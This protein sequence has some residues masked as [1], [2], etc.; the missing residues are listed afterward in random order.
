[1]NSLLMF[2]G[3]LD[4]TYALAKLLRET[5]D[6]VIVH[7][8]HLMTNRWQHIAEAER[9]RKIVTYCHENMRPFVYTQ[10]GIDH[11]RFVS[12]GMDLIA[13]GFEAGM[14]TGNYEAVTG[15]KINRWVIGIAKDDG[16]PDRRFEQAQRCL[17][18]N[19]QSKS[20]K[21]IYPQLFIF[22]RVEP[23]EQA[24][25]LSRELFDLTWSCIRPQGVPDQ[26]R[27]CGQCHKCK[28]R[29]NAGRVFEMVDA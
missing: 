6:E 16:V 9:C 1:M 26:I 2:S 18:Y 5:D 13:A 12:V 29:E 11:R 21:G 17:E 23:S 27:A 3:G 19:C 10:S 28:R 14:V 4:S 25:Y 15:K 22:P 24:R 8:I 7:H 20:R